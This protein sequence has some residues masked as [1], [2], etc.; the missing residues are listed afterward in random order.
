LP[1]DSKRIEHQPATGAIRDT[2]APLVVVMAAYNEAGAIGST[3]ARIPA[4]ICCVG[5]S[6]IV[7]VD[8]ATD[9]TAAEAREAG[10]YVWEMPDNRGQGTALRLGYR[11]ARERGAKYI[12]T[13]DADGQYD[14][15]E[16]AR[17]V[18]PLVEDD[19][20]FVTGS[21]RLGVAHTTD[22]VRGAGVVV[23]AWLIS[24]LTGQRITDPA[25]GLRAMQA[26]VTEAVPLEQTQYQAAELLVGAL[27]H[28]F[29]V[30]E[31]PSTMYPRAAGT[32][33]KGNNLVYGL[34]FARVILT[35]WWRDRGSARQRQPAGRSR[36]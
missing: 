17:V 28:G 2:P 32:T 35:T 5:V 1:A 22:R 11:L 36:I 34:R 21:R 29:R 4:E 30:V 24:L 9:A 26:A 3:L 19:A 15:A 25:N 7:V 12:A 10:A 23:F 16:L 8:G 14:P 6:V 20:D 31:V 13:L 33:K 27:L 18:A